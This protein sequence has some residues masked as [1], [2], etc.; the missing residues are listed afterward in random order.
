MGR[1][2]AR[3]HTLRPIVAQLAAHELLDQ[4][5]ADELAR[6]DMVPART[7]VTPGLG[8]SA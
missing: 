8:G 3:D 2:P 5:L 1:L 4:A 6:T 7:A